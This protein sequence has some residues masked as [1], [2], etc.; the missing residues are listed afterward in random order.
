MMLCC[1]ALL[2]GCADKTKETLTNRKIPLEDVTEFYYT[3]DNI[4]FDASFQRYR[5]YKEDGK[6]MFEHETR[7]RPGAYG[8]TTKEDV[9]DAGAIALTPEEWEDALS[10]LQSG[11]VSARKDDGESGGAG[12]WTF[13]YWKN[14]KGKYQVFEFST[15]EARTHFEGYCASLAEEK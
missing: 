7:N 14:D 12:P 3:Y 6:Y 9:T 13:I 5:F 4:H 2:F 10:L 15:V 8:P 11:T 1:T